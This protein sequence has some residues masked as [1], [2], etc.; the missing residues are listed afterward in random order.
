MR[1][2][3]LPL[4]CMFSLLLC[5]KYGKAQEYVFNGSLEYGLNINWV[6]SVKP[7]AAATMKLKQGPSVKDGEVELEIDLQSRGGDKYAVKS[8]TTARVKNDSIYLLRFWARESKEFAF[9]G[10]DYVAHPDFAQ[11]IVTI[12]GESG[13]KHEVL[14]FL[15]QG[16][17][18]FHLPFKTFDKELT[19]SFYPQTEGRS[20]YI[21]GVEVLDQTHHKNI[22]VYN[23]Y[24]WN[25]KRSTTGRTWLAGDNDIS[26]ELPDGRTLWVFNDSFISGSDNDVN[27][28]TRNDLVRI[29]RFVRNAAV[30]ENPDGTLIDLGATDRN[31]NGQAAFF[32]TVEEIVVDGSQKNFYWVGDMIMEGDM[33]KVYLVEE[34]ETGGLHGTGR[35]YIASISYPELELVKIERQASFGLGYETAFVEDDTI[36]LYKK[37]DGTFVARTPVGNY[38]GTEMWEFWNGTSW[39]K[40]PSA[41]VSIRSGDKVEDVIKLED[42]SYALITGLGA[43]S[44]DIYLEFAQSPQ[45]PWTHRTLVYTRPSDWQYWAY[46]PNFQKQL[47]NGNYS[48]SYSV[49]AFL[50][51]FFSSWSFVDKFWYRQRH[52]QIDVLGLSPYSEGYDCSG[53]KGGGAYID[54]CGECVG[55]STGLEP[56]VSGAAILYS[57]CDYAGTQ[58]GLGVGEYTMEDLVEKGFS[59]DLLSSI[60]VQEGY[61]VVLYSDD[62][63]TGNSTLIDG[64]SIPCLSS[65][66]F[67]NVTTSVVVRRNGVADMA[68][69]YVLQNKLTNLVMDV[70]DIN[71]PGSKITQKVYNGSATSQR[72]TFNYLGNGY[73]TITNTGANQLL[74]ID[75]NSTEPGAALSLSA[76][77][78]TDLGGTVSAQ[79][80]D[81]PANEGIEKLIDNSSSTKYLTFHS[82]GWV[83][84]QAPKAFLINAYSITSAN[85]ADERDPYSWTLSGSNDGEQ[86]TVL[87]ARN[88]QTFQ[89]RFQEKAF[90]I[91]GNTVPYS[92]YRLHMTSK[93]ASLLQLSEWKLFAKQED[94]E[95]QASQ[96]FIVQRTDDGY[97][98][99]YNKNS[100]LLI[101]VLNNSEAQPGSLV[102]QSMDFHQESALWR[103]VSVDNP[104]NLVPDCAGVLGG[105]A[106]VDKCGLCYGGT[107][108]KDAC[109][110]PPDCFGTLGGDAFID[111]CGNCVGGETGL[112][113]CIIL[114]VHD[115]ENASHL[116]PNP[117]RDLLNVNLGKNWEG[118]ELRIF[119]TLGILVW[120]GVYQNESIDVAPFPPGVYVFKAIGGNATFEAR[121][122][123][124]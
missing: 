9:E 22:D 103:V 100:D 1:T 10:P 107:T 89:S 26:L 76:L 118:K 32:E 58:I 80:S 62:N 123:K 39:V 57:D 54:Q 49:N 83:Q 16:S 15:R 56:C 29:G 97:Y 50:P 115:D 23:T 18:T 108:G 111:E 60:K 20:Y 40:D 113:P 120:Q 99:I 98:K 19:I 21:D 17:T 34:D 25:N 66:G 70:E 63:H 51:L 38:V 30:V 7:G 116:Y 124:Q 109:I 69:T 78:I 72:F 11:L 42:N 48:I 27:D 88:H 77:D 67:D 59:D 73:Y 75:H 31:N 4:L 35:S 44:R 94:G 52:I 37:N 104:D 79:Y 93:A 110:P 122:I 81:S 53:V 8:S 105:E 46:L 68:G 90:S 114:S 65:L 84:Y 119:N 121:F 36:Y 102:R 87:D 5:P 71:K 117:V 24:I 85:D 2:K 106:M 33:I 13:H 74:Q 45:G 82:S 3:L 95:L 64:D 14:Y 12:E 6:H 86:W 47:S 55:G 112:E 43:L 96:Q 61:S 41:A 92:Y 28:T 91:A 101:E